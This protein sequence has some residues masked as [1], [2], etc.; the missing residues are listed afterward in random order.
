MAG[1]PNCRPNVKETT[2]LS[3]GPEEQNPQRL[4][5]YLTAAQRTYAE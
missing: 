5:K 1:N 4:D 2:V 3:T